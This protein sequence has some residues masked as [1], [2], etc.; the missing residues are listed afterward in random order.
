VVGVE[1]VLADGSLVRS[2]LEDPD[3]PGMVLSLGSLGVVTRLWLQ[4]LPTYDLA[5]EVI[6]DVP[7]SAISR[8]GTELLSSAWSVSLFTSFR[9]PQTLDSVWRKSRVDVESSPGDTWG[10]RLA[11]AAV[12]PIL[13]LDATTATEQLGRIG[14]WHERL[15]HFRATSTPSVGDELQSE[16][17]VPLTSLG[18]LW[19][20]LVA[21]S[22]KFA[23]ALRV[24]EIRAVA[25]DGLW[26]SPFH[27]R[28]TLAVHATWVSSINSVI[29]ALTALEEILEPYE[30]RPHWAKV[31]RSWDP[32][33]VTEKYPAIVQFQALAARLDPRMCFVND[34][35]RRTGIR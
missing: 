3:F 13:G 12:H 18:E 29:P 30:P 22:P 5:Q 9:N 7:S 14:P 32:E 21:G 24:M 15:P 34:Y 1:L 25:D 26:L 4:M 28:Q 11:T 2:R 27:D 35:L 17:F 10:G 19:P 23:G 33:H 16:F 8:N 6:L 20:Q 31:F